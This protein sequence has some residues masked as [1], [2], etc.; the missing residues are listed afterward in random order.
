MP[1][2]LLK[3]E[4]LTPLEAPEQFQEEAIRKR[5]ERKVAQDTPMMRALGLAHYWQ[6]LLG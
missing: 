5:H 4:I 2:T 6:R 3:R 1:Y